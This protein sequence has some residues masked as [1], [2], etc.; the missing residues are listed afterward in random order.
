MQN[1]LTAVY[2][3]NHKYIIYDLIYKIL[4]RLGPVPL[5][6]VSKS[7]YIFLTYV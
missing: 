5:A 2:D 6:S 1:V 3:G 4:A 7:Q